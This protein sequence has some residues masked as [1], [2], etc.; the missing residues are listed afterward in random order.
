M[1]EPDRVA[2]AADGERIFIVGVRQA[3]SRDG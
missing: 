2:Q 1:A 3:A